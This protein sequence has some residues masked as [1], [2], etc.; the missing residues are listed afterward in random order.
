MSDITAKNYERVF[1]HKKKKNI[2]IEYQ[3]NPSEDSISSKAGIT[4]IDDNGKKINKVTAYHK[5]KIYRQAKELRGRLRDSMCTK[6]EC[7]KPNKE[8]VNKMIGEMRN[9][10]V[11][12]YKLAM[13]VVG[14]EP[15]DCNP[16]LL[17]K[18][19]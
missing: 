10:R 14:A 9:P 3:R 16:E 13:Q 11:T 5:N 12:A 17:R 4:L 7:W 19:R 18:G 15:K 6:S 1:G 8:N 2:K